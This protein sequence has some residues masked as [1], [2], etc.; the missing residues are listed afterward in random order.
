MRYA[1]LDAVAAIDDARGADDVAARRP[2]H[3]HRLA[4]R[5]AGGDDVLDDQHAIGL[6]D[7]EPAP[8]RERAVL[9]LDE[10]RADAERARDLVADDDAAERRR[11]D[12]RRP[13]ITGALRD[14]AAQRLG[15]LRMLQHQR[16]LQ[17]ARAVQ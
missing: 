14:R 17:I 5:S 7:D 3:L 13:Q 1:E 11:E 12:H 2:R 10:D 9:A 4:R 15:M 8:Q 6:A 16:A